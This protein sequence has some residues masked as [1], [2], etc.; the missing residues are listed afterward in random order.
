MHGIK[1]I[2]FSRATTTK[3]STKSIICKSYW[4]I[5]M[6]STTNLQLETEYLKFG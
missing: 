2:F 3:P 5:Y 1:L 4:P 6:I